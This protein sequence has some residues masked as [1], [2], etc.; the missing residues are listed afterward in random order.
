MKE[1]PHVQVD[2]FEPITGGATLILAELNRFNMFSS[3]NRHYYSLENTLDAPPECQF[4]RIQSPCSTL[5]QRG[6]LFPYRA[7]SS[8]L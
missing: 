2:N 3:A 4:Y 8:V 6:K 5:E 1:K 7:S